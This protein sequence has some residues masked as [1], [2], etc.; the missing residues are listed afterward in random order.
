[1]QRK[2]L[3]SCLLSGPLA[4]E[5]K[6]F[7]LDGV[8]SFRTGVFEPVKRPGEGCGA[9]HTANDGVGDGL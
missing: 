6:G 5:T 1:M 9:G 2:M 3:F 7:Y 8:S 4:F